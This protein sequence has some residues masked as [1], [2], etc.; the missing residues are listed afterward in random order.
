MVNT[1]CSSCTRLQSFEDGE[2]GRAWLKVEVYDGGDS[3]G[4]TIEAEFCSPACIVAFFESE[5]V[6]IRFPDRPPNV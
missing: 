1:L 5:D 4:P 6:G 3:G 2:L